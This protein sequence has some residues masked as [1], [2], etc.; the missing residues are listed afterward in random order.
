[1][2]Q[3]VAL[4]VAALLVPG[5]GSVLRLRE[6]S[7]VVALIVRT[8]PPGAQV[9]IA[10]IDYAW[11]TPCE[12]ADPAIRRG[13][14]D[15]TVSLEGYEMVTRRLGWNGEVPARLELTL[16]PR[17]GTIVVQNAPP[18]ALVMILRTPPGVKDVASVVRL[19]SENEESLKSAIESLPEA[20]AAIVQFRIRELSTSSAPAVAEAARKKDPGATP[21]GREG[22]PE[23]THRVTAD[24][25][26]TARLTYVPPKGNLHLLV[27][28]PGS[29]DFMK[30]DIKPDLRSLV[31][32]ALPAAPKPVDPPKPEPPKPLDVA[33]G[34]PLGKLTVK[35]AGD[36]VRVSAGGKVVAEVPTHPEESVKLAVPREKVLVEFLDAKTGAVTGSVELVPE[37][38]PAAAAPPPADGQRIGKI[39]LVHRQFGTFVRLEP[40][41]EL[42]IGDWVSIHRDGQ[43]VVRAKVLRVCAG[44]SLYPAGAAMLS[45]EAAPARKGDEARRAKP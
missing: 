32:I 41:Q 21:P 26:G 23:V 16:V 28:R 35:A 7:E 40:G 5:C 31:T 1:M 36:R 44:D 2:R 20:D 29:P 33:P 19:W 42:G 37:A 6:T 25:N 10:R 34:V 14:L 17:T 12:I 9:R 18:G 8:D 43:E 13:P 39:Q 22:P 15:V 3:R 4:L 45:P 24:A 38:D 27:T 30:A 11:S